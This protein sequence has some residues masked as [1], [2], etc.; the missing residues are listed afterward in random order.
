MFTKT[1]LFLC[2]VAADFACGSSFRLGG[3]FLSGNARN[4]PGLFV[5]VE[6][7]FTESSFS[8]GLES[9]FYFQTSPSGLSLPLQGAVYY[10][11]RDVGGGVVPGLGLSGGVLISL[12]AGLRTVD[13]LFLVHP[14]LDFHVFDSLRGFVRMSFGNLGSTFQF[15]PLL[16][17][18][19][20]LDD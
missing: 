11:F 10:R 20:A 8:W 9:G 14:S 18:S 12:G 13:A 19:W 16:G 1:L 3:G 2:L 4:V 5:G 17:V 15:A 7:E 6:K